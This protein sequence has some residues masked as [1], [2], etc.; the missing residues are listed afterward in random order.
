MRS[1][2]DAATEAVARAIA[3]LQKDAQHERELR[4]AEHRALVAELNARIASVSALERQ[5]ADKLATLK[6]G[7]P[8]TSVT[9]EQVSPI[10]TAECERLFSGLPI[11]AKGDRGEDADP[12]LVTLL[13]DEKVRQAVA[14]LPPAKDGTS[15]TVKDVAPLI[16]EQVRAAIV[17]LPKPENG[18]DADP[19]LIRSMVA[20][21]VD[22]LPPAKDGKDADPAMVEGLVAEAVE[23]AVAALP[24]AENGKDADPEVISRMV[25][26][27][28]AKLPPAEPGKDADPAVIADMVARAVAD[29]P[30]PPPGKDADPEL[31]EAL[32]DEKVRSAV[33]ALPPPEKGEP[34][35]TGKLPIAREWEDRVYGES[36]VATHCGGLYQ[37]LRATGKEPP[38]EDWICLARGGKDGQSINIRNTYSEAE[39]YARLDM[40]SL[41]GALFVARKDN[42]GPC[43]GEDWQ[44]AAMRGKPGKPGPKGDPGKVITASVTEASI[45]EDGRLALINADGTTVECDLYPVLSK[46]G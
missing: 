7:E 16:E 22:A 17:D 4:D 23:R 14:A 33:A 20:E 9:V 38:H 45:S 19:E 37:A 34:G 10:I 41:N 5:V 6:D 28:V 24:P 2:L 26:E 13:V 44:L 40:A 18:K 29:L 11:P 12:E 36:E 42:P 3:G 25:D 30:P 27:A 43:P 35:A 46:I 39:T 31:V 32:V 1:F 8:G 15:V 21:A